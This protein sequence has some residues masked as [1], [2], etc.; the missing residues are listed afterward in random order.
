MR[1]H[2]YRLTNVVVDAALSALLGGGIY[3]SGVEVDGVEYAF[4]MHA[5]SSTGVWMQEPTRLPAGFANGQA[6]LIRSLGVAHTTIPPRSLRRVV[7]ELMQQWPGN[8]YDVISRN[9]NHFAGAFIG[10][11]LD[12][13]D[14]MRYV[15]AW[16][17]RAASES[18]E[19]M[20]ALNAARATLNGCF[21]HP[22]RGALNLLAPRAPSE[23]RAADTPADTP[24]SPTHVSSCGCWPRRP[25]SP[26]GTSRAPEL[27][28]RRIAADYDRTAAAAVARPP[29]VRNRRRIL[30]G[31]TA[32]ALPTVRS[33]GVLSAHAG[34]A[35][36]AWP[37]RERWVRLG[38]LARWMVG[39]R[40]AVAVHVAPRVQSANS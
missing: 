7:V 40:G 3:H 31:K 14:G 16:V 18:A 27:W 5:H 32:T 10:A 19:V 29:G 15:P 28:A 9:C 25:P 2:V 6:V 35:A 24:R 13:K 37:P 11:L 1:L 30:T 34:G 36:A 39:A 8:A 22:G 12:A 20:R 17:N 26:R 38:A 23:M 4:G 33:D 21:A